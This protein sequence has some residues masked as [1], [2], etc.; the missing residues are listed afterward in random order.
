LG[1]STLDV[2][3]RRRGSSVAVTV[4]GKSGSAS[5]EVVL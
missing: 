4:L 5:V 1:S 2:L 3:L